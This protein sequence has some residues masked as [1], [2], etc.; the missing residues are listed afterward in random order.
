MY[1]YQRNVSVKYNFVLYMSCSS[2]CSIIKIIYSPIHNEIFSY[3]FLNY[4]TYLHINMTFCILS[5]AF[6]KTF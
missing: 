1:D 5:L 3:F 2:S 6:Y 4:F